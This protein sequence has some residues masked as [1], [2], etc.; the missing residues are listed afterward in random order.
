MVVAPPRDT[1]PPPG[2]SIRTLTGLAAYRCG[3]SGSC[4]RAGWPI[5]VEPAPLRLLQRADADGLLSPTTRPWLND[6]I[7]G[8][9]QDNGCIF[10]TP[11][12]VSG[13]CMVETR[14]GTEALPISCRQ[15]PRLLLVDPHGW[16]QSLSAWCGTTARLL[17]GSDEPGPTAP[18]EIDMFLSF[19]HIP[20]DPRVHLEAL[21]ARETWPPLLRPGVLA[22][23]EAYQRWEQR[24]IAD[25]LR[26]AAHGRLACAV[27]L[28]QLLRWTDLIREWRPVDGNLFSRVGRP[29]SP[30]RWSQPADPRPAVERLRLVEAELMG[31]VPEQWRARQWP[32]GLTDAVYE[33]VP[34]SRGRA[35]A[36]LA[37]YL[38]TRLAASWVA[39]QGRG[40][41]SVLA[42]LVSSLALVA[43]ALHDTATEEG[44]LTLGHMRSAIRASDWLQL[45]LLDRDVWADWCS[46]FETA[47]DAAP[48]LSV[49]AAAGQAIDGLPWAPAPAAVRP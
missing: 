43:L 15:F 32:Y 24:A 17:A 13:G 16:H 25:W 5:P 46:H 37:K 14:L 42:S 49:V 34:L 4:C 18:A 39:Y 40:L 26:P 30:T 8:H 27:A 33:G 23:L 22:G 48:L 1:A 29:W 7:L 20:T 10:H 2:A 38:A 35:E 31:L 11:G 3:H 19:D 45:H 28:A 12:G 21:D 44:P 6:G 47:R 9:T 36:A 41:R